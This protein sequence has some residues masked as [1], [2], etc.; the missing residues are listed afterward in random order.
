MIKKQIQVR[1]F[2]DWNNASP[3]FVEADLV[4]HCGGRVDGSFLNT[5]VLTDIASAWTEFL[6][7]LRKSEED[8]VGALK[9]A[10]KLLPFSLLGLDTDNGSEFINYKL[11]KFCEE[12]KI[13][14]TRSRAYHSNDQAH[15]EEKNGSIVRR[16]MGYDR[17]E[18]NEAW[19]ALAALYAK[20]RLYVNFFQPSMKLLSKQRCGTKIR[21]LYDKAQ[22][23]YQRL[24]LS[25]HINEEIK[26]NLKKQYETLDPLSLLQELKDLQGQFFQYAWKGPV[27]KTVPLIVVQKTGNIDLRMDEIVSMVGAQKS[28]TYKSKAGDLSP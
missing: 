21:K 8:V 12:Q 28:R 20:L 18:G 14:F 26:A 16:I 1:T 13:T 10:Q 23:P 2:A 25:P 27:N 4:A 5:L 6:P 22:T 19:N 9:V 24:S 3:G 17:Y 7:L 15:V 11:L